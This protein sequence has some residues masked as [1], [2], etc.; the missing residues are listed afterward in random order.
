MALNQKKIV[1]YFVPILMFLVAAFQL[2]QVNNEGLTRWK[3]GGYGMYS[4][5]HYSSYEVWTTY[6]GEIKEIKN[7][8]KIDGITP[9]ESKR[10]ILKVKLFPNNRNLRALAKI[11][12]K[13]EDY[14]I[15]IQVWKPKINLNNLSYSRVLL[16]EIT[17]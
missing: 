15:T 17:E 7:I 14:P 2:F 16:K 11:L 9:E 12:K 13:D 6:K 3:G 10:L 1:K 4:E 8:E 5:I